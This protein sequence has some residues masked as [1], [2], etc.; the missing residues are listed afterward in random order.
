[1][2]PL[3]A[4]GKG[5]IAIFFRFRGRKQLL[6]TKFYVKKIVFSCFSRKKDHFFEIHEKSAHFR[7]SEGRYGI[8]QLRAAHFAQED[9][10]I[11][12]F[13]GILRKTGDRLRSP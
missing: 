4:V 5:V 11:P 9:S 3:D 13:R 10:F 12:S 6:Y 1:M 7:P 2:R 8:F